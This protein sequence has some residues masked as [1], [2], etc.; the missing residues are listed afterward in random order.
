MAN[1]K[2]QERYE[3]AVADLGF[4]SGSLEAQLLWDYTRA[5][6]EL[7][8]PSRPVTDAALADE[9]DVWVIETASGYVRRACEM[10]DQ[11]SFFSEPSKGATVK[12]YVRDRS[13]Q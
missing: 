6:E 1:A 3:A 5:V 8:A 13:S 9:R 12:R 11:A 7:L 10:R 2:L 4:A